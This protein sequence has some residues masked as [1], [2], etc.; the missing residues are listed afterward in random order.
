MSLL[1]TPEFPTHKIRRCKEIIMVLCYEFWSHCGVAM[2]DQDGRF[3]NRQF[4]KAIHHINESKEKI[5]KVMSTNTENAL[6][7][8]QHPLV[9]FLKRL[10]AN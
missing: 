1:S 6:D 8:I 5:L 9:I 7:K 4:L 2:G 10:L 3:R